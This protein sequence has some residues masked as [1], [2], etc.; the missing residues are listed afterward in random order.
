MITQK[1]EESIQLYQTGMPMLKVC[2]TTGIRFSTLQRHLQQRGLSRSNKQNSRKYQVDHGYFNTID[3]EEKA[4]WLGFLYAD[5]YVSK[6]AKQ[7][8]VGCALQKSDS[9]HLDKLKQSLSEV[10]I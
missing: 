5:G 6:R 9:P 4:Y 3:S 8:L 7:K 1:L 10:S 2:S